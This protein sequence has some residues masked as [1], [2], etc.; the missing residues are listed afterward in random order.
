M[1]N[2]LF[3]MLRKA[4]SN[5]PSIFGNKGSDFRP[6][7]K[8]GTP[9]SLR[10][11]PF[12]RAVIERQNVVLDRLLEEKRLEVLQAFGLLGCKVVCL[13]EVLFDVVELPDVVLDRR[14]RLE[15][16]RDA[17]NRHCHSR[18]AARIPAAKPK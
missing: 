1:L 18:I 8:S 12:E 13:A 14:S 2:D 9:G 4:F 6:A 10:V 3:L 17:M 16:P 7:I 15:L 5:N 11:E